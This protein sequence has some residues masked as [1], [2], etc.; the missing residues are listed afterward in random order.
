MLNV[1]SAYMTKGIP[2][3]FSNNK[4]HTVEGKGLGR[5]GGVFGDVL[6]HSNIKLGNTC[7]TLSLAK[8]T[9]REI[10]RSVRQLI[11]FING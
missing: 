2:S 3:H 11:S 4:Q 9:L 6:F 10:T 7:K 5:G 8:V 1:V